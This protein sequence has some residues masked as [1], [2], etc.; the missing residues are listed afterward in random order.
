[1]KNSFVLSLFR[2]SFLE[3]YAGGGNNSCRFGMLLISS[4]DGEY[5][6]KLVQS[7]ESR[8]YPATIFYG[9]EPRHKNNFKTWPL[10]ILQLLKNHSSY[11]NKSYSFGKLLIIDS[12]AN[13]RLLAIVSQKILSRL[14]VT[15]ERGS[16]KSRVCIWQF[17][18]LA[19]LARLD[20]YEP[21]TNNSCRFGMLLISASE[22]VR[23]PK[24]WGKRWGLSRYHFYG[25][26]PRNK[27]NCKTWP[28]A[29]FAIARQPL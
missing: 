28:I 20:K 11:L 10:P 6:P 29:I 22:G 24:K 16:E 18:E 4:S 26:E 5:P 2:W 19:R 21:V 9:T 13:N 17:I 7:I 1:M 3:K 15:R 14:N 12:D 23:P 25:T 27:N 8:G